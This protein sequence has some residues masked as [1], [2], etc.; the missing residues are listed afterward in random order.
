MSKRATAQKPSG[1]RRGQS[2]IQNR[3]AA[4][5]QSTLVLRV[6]LVGVLLAIG[7]WVLLRVPPGLLIL[8][9]IVILLIVIALIWIGLALRPRPDEELA[10]QGTQGEPER[11]L[12]QLAS[13]ESAVEIRPVQLSDLKL[14]GHDEFEY[15]IGALLETMGVAF[16]LEKVGGAR[17]RG[18]DLRG[19]DRF[20]CLFIVQ[21][22]LYF[23][24]KITPEKTREFRGTMGLHGASEGWFVTTSSFTAQAEA[25]VRDLS[26]KGRIVLV[27]GQ[28]LIEHIHTCWEALP[29]QWQQRLT[30]IILANS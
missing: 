23:G 27:N 5:K 21:C 17:D 12:I 10:E 29:A 15:F 16:D 25:E 11:D 7:I 22:K 4:S 13:A 28:T 26:Y 8:L 30:H 14:L 24:H 18:I 1:R 20:N 6:L 2:H 9:L 19:K 3:P